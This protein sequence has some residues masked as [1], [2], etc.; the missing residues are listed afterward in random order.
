MA[1]LLNYNNLAN[2][3]DNVVCGYDD[4]ARRIR[5]HDAAVNCKSAVFSWTDM[6]ENDK[7]IDERVPCPEEYVP[8]E[9]TSILVGDARLTVFPKKEW[10][11]GTAGVTKQIKLPCAGG[12]GNRYLRACTLNR[13]SKPDEK[14]RCYMGKYSTNVK[15]KFGNTLDRTR[16]NYGYAD[17]SRCPVDWQDNSARDRYMMNYCGTFDGTNG[18]NELCNEWWDRV[19]IPSIRD[20]KMISFCSVA[21]NKDHPSCACINAPPKE[22]TPSLFAWAFDDKCGNAKNKAYRTQGMRNLTYQNC[23]QIVDIT[24]NTGSNI[25]D[26][27]ISQTCTINF[28]D[29]AR[30][31]VQPPPP[32]AKLPGTPAV[33]PPPARPPA[34]P[35]ILPP[36]SPSATPPAPITNIA[37]PNPNFGAFDAQ[38]PSFDVSTVTTNTSSAPP[39][40]PPPSNFEPPLPPAQNSPPPF[41]QP[42]NISSSP[43]SNSS[44][45]I[46]NPNTSATSFGGSSGSSNNTTTGSS[47]ADVSS[48]LNS[49]DNI[50]FEPPA[51]V[52]VTPAGSGVANAGG[53][54][55][56]GSSSGGSNL[57]NV[58]AKSDAAANDIKKEEGP[59]AWYWIL[60]IIICILAVG[61]VAFFVKMRHSKSVV[62][63]SDF[64][65][66]Q[67]LGRVG[68]S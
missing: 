32:P 44:I 23:S 15:S 4:K 41:F 55:S 36:A 63:R 14:A 50:V 25:Y 2:L 12:K 45:M 9:K 28:P 67:G 13:Y 58:A 52:Q 5:C 24:R 56:G 42:N 65:N 26:N 21:Q 27:K 6:R 62:S 54:G 30:A 53:G 48:G 60:L 16:S 3:P 38:T 64:M 66:G 59:F 61:S 49:F 1:D 20:E 51:D 17:V 46:D 7:S 40:P 8:F 11:T 34:M 18:S 10:P 22:G 47:S 43:G 35:P 68:Q 33:P 31:P 39:P 37:P 29:L 19:N 57:G